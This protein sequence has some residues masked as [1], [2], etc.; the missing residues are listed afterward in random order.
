MLVYKHEGGSSTRRLTLLKAGY[1][2]PELIRKPSKRRNGQ[3]P[4]NDN[5]HEGKRFREL[6]VAT[7]NIREFVEETEEL[8]TELH[9]RKTDIAT[10][11][12]TK[13]K[14]KGLEDIGNYVMIYYGITANQ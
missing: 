6:K 13:K 11:T 1:L 8:Q 12:E 4:H 14:N 3:Y 9:T 7:W 5:K 2:L 10:I